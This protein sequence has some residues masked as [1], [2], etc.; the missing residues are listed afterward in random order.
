MSHAA[1][2]EQRVRK[3]ETSGGVGGGG[4][5]A[6]ADITGKPA[7]FPP[8][9]HTHG[10]A[11]VVEVDFGAF[12][13]ALYA[14]VDVAAPAISTA[15]RVQVW[16]H[17]AATADHTADEHLIDPPRVIA[18]PASAGVGFTVHAFSNDTKRHHGR[19]AVAWEWR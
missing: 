15:D 5:V 4:P 2:L 10:A 8:S 6:W 11:G 17:P 9:T 13:G 19:Y 14:T 18:G 7:T 12:P 3:V 1:E 16:V